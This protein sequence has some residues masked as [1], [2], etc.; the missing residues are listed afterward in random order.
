MNL[1]TELRCIE[2]Q[3]QL[4]PAGDELK[5]ESGCRVPVVRGIPRFVD[6]SNYAAG[7][8]LQWNQFR[9]TQL[10][11]YTGTTIS[12][13]RL[14]RTVGG[15]LEVLSGRAVLEVGWGA[16]PFAAVMVARGSRV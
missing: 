13:D 4:L 15:K 2:H 1:P 7:F 11:S 5:C 10:D 16:G 9:K 14:T 8:G 6:S 12:K 3:Q